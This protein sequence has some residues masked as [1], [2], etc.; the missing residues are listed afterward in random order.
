M[1]GA[2]IELAWKGAPLVADTTA[3]GEVTITFP[4]TNITVERLP[5]NVS[6]GVT[7]VGLRAAHLR[8]NSTGPVAVTIIPAAAVDP[9]GSAEVGVDPAS[10]EGSEGDPG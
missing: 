10:H 3:D 9:E 6:L 7:G 8:P 5:S 2:P 1:D 4:L